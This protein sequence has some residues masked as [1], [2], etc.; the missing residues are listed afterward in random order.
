VIAYST[1]PF[2]G[3]R[4]GLK[5]KKDFESHSKIEVYRHFQKQHPEVLTGTGMPYTKVEFE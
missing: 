1:C 2:C 4:I 5:R 3:L